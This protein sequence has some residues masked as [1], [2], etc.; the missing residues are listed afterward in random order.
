MTEAPVA[1]ITTLITPHPV[2]ANKIK[3]MSHKM[4]SNQLSTKY[5]DFTAVVGE[6][7]VVKERKPA[8]R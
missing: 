8:P 5:H 6:V 2:V 1:S 7:E 4:G 3:K